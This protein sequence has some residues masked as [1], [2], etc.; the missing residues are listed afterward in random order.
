MTRDEMWHVDYL[1]EGADGDE[2]QEALIDLAEERG[3]L[4]GG[5][6]RR[7]RGETMAVDHE[8]RIDRIERIIEIYDERFAEGSKTMATHELRLAGLEHSTPR[9]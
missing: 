6:I 2:L 9:C 3:W 8:R 4:C 1:F 5:V 7:Y